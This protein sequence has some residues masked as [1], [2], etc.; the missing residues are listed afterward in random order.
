MVVVE[1]DDDQTR[2]TVRFDTETL[3]LGAYQGT[4]N[5]DA[6]VLTLV[7]FSVPVDGYRLANTLEAANGQIRFAGFST[8]TFESPVVLT[9][10]F[11]NLAAVGPETLLSVDI[12]VLGNPQSQAVPSAMI[13]APV[14]QFARVVLP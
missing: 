5:F 10:V 6:K 13:H 14:R 12:D 4:F 7:D 11:K 1:Y 9:L 2:V 3:E 8:K